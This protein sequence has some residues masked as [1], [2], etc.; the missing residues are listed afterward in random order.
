MKTSYLSIGKVARQKNIS[1]KALR[2][3]DKI[4][5]FV[6]AYINPQTNYRYYTP[7]QLPL[8]D[9][10]SLCVNLGI[11]LKTLP[12]YVT[13]GVFDFTGLLEDTRLLAKEK[14]HSIR[15]TLRTLEEA[16]G[17]PGLSVPS[18][19]SR[20]FLPREFLLALPINPGTLPPYDGLILRLFI[21]ARQKGFSVENPSCILYRFENQTWKKYL[22]VR[23]LLPAEPD[24]DTT[25]G[26]IQ[27]SEFRI[28][29]IPEGNYIKRLCSGFLREIP[30][31]SAGLSGHPSPD[32]A[33]S[34]LE[35]TTGSCEN[36]DGQHSCEL[37]ELP[38]QIVQII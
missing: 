4:G 34:L 13:D 36:T 17:T 6:P 15:L 14:I 28:F 37:I 31:C 38:T 19:C 27:N 12:S 3:Y 32:T 35:R 16:A 7:D 33:F 21:H 23:L 18:P 2:Y 1:I 11:P 25:A 30:G 20:I 26:T 10:I 22:A 24:A 29:K 8:L 5:I 9:A